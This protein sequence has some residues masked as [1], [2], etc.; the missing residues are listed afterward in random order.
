[1]KQEKALF[2]LHYSPPIHGAAKVG[3]TI[4]KSSVI[5]DAFKTRYIKIKSSN[6]LESIGTFRLSKIWFFLGL[7]FNVVYQLVF[8]RPK[9]IYFTTSP[10]GFAFYRDIVISI[11]VKIYRIFNKNC[12]VFYHYHAKGIYEFTKHSKKAKNLTNFF[13]SKVS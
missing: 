5:N 12:E 10:R 4:L 7:L 6:N 1:M 11:A 8:F 2:I 13:V 3:D 9:I